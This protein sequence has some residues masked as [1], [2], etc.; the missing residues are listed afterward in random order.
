MNQR[1]ISEDDA[2]DPYGTLIPISDSVF[3][4]PFD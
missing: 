4:H 3:N 1:P 2:F